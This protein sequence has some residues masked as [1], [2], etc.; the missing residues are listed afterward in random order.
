[1]SRV[2][3]V[4][5][6]FACVAIGGCQP[7]S[8]ENGDVDSGA[9]PIATRG[10]DAADPVADALAA[11]AGPAHDAR[12]PDA[13]R[14][15]PSDVELAADWLTGEFNSRA[16]ATADRR[17][18]DVHLYAM[19]VWPERE[20]G[21]WMY[22]QQSR[23]DDEDRIYEAPYRQRVYHVHA[24]EDG[25]VVS[26]VYRIAAEERFV[27]PWTDLSV[28]DA[29]ND[30]AL[31]KAE[32]CDVSLSRDGDRFVGGTIGT[33][34]R[35][36]FGGHATSSVTLTAEG[37]Q[38]LDLLYDNAGQIINGLTEESAPYTFEKIENFPLE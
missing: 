1:M 25:T 5:A 36:S 6:L 9:A 2:S 30:E 17:Y 23:D 37:I 29:L 34:C 21:V 31:Q 26:T 35:L 3:I 19:Q 38:S 7:A 12:A 18:F 15:A 20:D 32:G 13:A 14:P 4:A 16:Q 33:R 8:T 10:T 11:D 24:G 28:L 27:D 22:V